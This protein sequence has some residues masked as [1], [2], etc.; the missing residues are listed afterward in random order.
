MKCKWNVYEVNCK[1]YTDRDDIPV[2]M[3]DFKT[4]VVVRGNFTTISVPVVMTNV[5]RV[6]LTSQHRNFP[7]CDTLR[8]LP[9]HFPS[10]V[11][12]D[13]SGGELTSFNFACLPEESVHFDVVDLDANLIEVVEG[14]EYLRSSK[15]SE[16]HMNGNRISTFDFS[17]LPPT[18]RILKLKRNRISLLTSWDKLAGSPSL[19]RI[20]L[21]LNQISNF[22]F[23]ALPPTIDKINL[24][25]NRL[26]D[27]NFTSSQLLPQLLLHHNPINCA[28]A[29]LRQIRHFN[30]VNQIAFLQ[31]RIHDD[32]DDDDDVIKCYMKHET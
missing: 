10:M 30:L 27:V 25:R 15:L 3:A 32:D 20:Y 7:N 2:S 19:Q 18:L 8:M 26:N 21:Q 31:R 9:T 1:H 17:C 12:L 11:K 22:N 6:H 23:S 16:L 14:C 24:S 29:T 5:K 4:S 28:C 13:L